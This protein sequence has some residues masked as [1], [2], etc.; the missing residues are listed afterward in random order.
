MDF[1]FFIAAIVIAGGYFDHRVKMK[2]LEVKV[3]NSEKVNLEE[4]LQSIKHRLVV[5]EKIVTDRR[6]QLEEEIDKL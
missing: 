1:W 2:N 4:E 5:L 6:Y 3:D